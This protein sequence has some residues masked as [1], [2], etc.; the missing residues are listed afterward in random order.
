[1]SILRVGIFSSWSVDI[2]RSRGIG[3]LRS[4]SLTSGISC[5][6]FTRG[7]VECFRFGGSC[8]AAFPSRLLRRVVFGFCLSL[9]PRDIIFWQAQGELSYTH[10]RRDPTGG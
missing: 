3:L 8:F 2:L 6:R 5:R 1:M 4:I 9:L 10:L 7:S